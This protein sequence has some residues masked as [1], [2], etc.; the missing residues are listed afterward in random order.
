MIFPMSNASVGS[1]GPVCAQMKIEKFL[2]VACRWD[3][4]DNN[5]LVTAPYGTRAE[6][7][8]T[9]IDVWQQD[10]VSLLPTVQGLTK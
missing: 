4:S 6:K 10:E 2:C 5:P 3:W 1:F 8:A 7:N 9:L